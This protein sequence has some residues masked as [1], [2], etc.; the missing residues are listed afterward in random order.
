LDVKS[1][2]SIHQIKSK[3]QQKL[4]VTMDECNLIFTDRYLADERTLLDY[5]IYP[6]S[7]LKITPKMQIFIK[8]D[9]RSLITLQVKLSDTIEQ[10]KRKI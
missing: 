6:N 2:D 5:G 7:I 9:E 10:I 1:S 4:N 8:M 3:I